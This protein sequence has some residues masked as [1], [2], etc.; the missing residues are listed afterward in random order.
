MPKGNVTAVLAWG[1]R[2]A[3]ATRL[4]GIAG[5]GL[6]EERGEFSCSEVV[7][8]ISVSG[9]ASCGGQNRTA[10]PQNGQNEPITSL[11]MPGRFSLDPT[12]QEA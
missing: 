6:H 3:S 9:E 2:N 11:K 1:I 8:R 7:R 12:G 5:K 4:M 10:T